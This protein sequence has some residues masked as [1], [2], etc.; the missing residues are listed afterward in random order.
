MH[1]VKSLPVSERLLQ[2]SQSAYCTLCVTG[3]VECL[4]VALTAAGIVA[5]S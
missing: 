3:Q 5:G 1:S 4:A 2:A